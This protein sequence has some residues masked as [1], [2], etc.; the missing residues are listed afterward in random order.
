MSNEKREFK[1]V[2]GESSL[3]FIK[4]STLAAEGIKGVILEGE[5]I[6]AIK[7][8]FDENKSDYKFQ[9][10]DGSIVIVNS[11]GSLAHQMAKVEVGSFV[12]LEYDGKKKLT[13]GKMAGK[14]AHMFTVLVA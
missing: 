2:G 6:G 11:T 9:K 13:K 4:A 14:E 8:N 10:E 7:N 5:Y 12:R 3:S 1:K